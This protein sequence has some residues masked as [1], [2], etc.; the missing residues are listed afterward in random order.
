M[1]AN[2][3]IIFYL[4]I[5]FLFC[6]QS[7]TEEISNFTAT[8][9]SISLE[10]NRNH[11]EYNFLLDNA[12]YIIRIKT[13]EKNLEINRNIPRFFNN[14]KFPLKKHFRII[15][16]DP[17]TKK[18]TLDINSDI[19]YCIEDKDYHNRIG[20][21]NDNGEIGLLDKSDT[22][23]SNDEFINNNFLWNITP[24]ILN[25]EDNNKNI[26]KVYYYVKNIGTGKYLRYRKEFNYYLTCDTES[27]LNFTNDN[28]FKF[29]RMYREMIHNENNE[30]LEKEPID[31]LIKYIDLKDPDLKREG[32]T[33]I[34]KDVE[35]KEIK[36]SVRSIFKNIPWI[37][38]IFI[39]MPN[40]KVKY[41]KSPEEIKDKIVYVKD[42][43][44]LN[45]DSASSPVFQFNL[46]RMKNFG[47]SENFILMD[48][49]YFIGKPLKKSNFFY[50][51]NGQVFPSIVTRDYYELSKNDLQNEVN[52]LLSSRNNL[53]SQSPEAFNFMQKNT[54][55]FL[56]EILGDDNSRYGMPLIEPSFTHNAIP[57]KQSDI[58]EL[59]DY[60]EKLY[61]HKDETLRGKQRE[62]FCLQP[63]TLLMSYGRNKYD[64]ISKTIT[65]RFYDLTN[66]RGRI[67]DELFV[68]NTSDRSYREIIY[69]N[70]INYLENLYPEKTP[71]ELEI[72]DIN[73]GKRIIE[74]DNNNIKND[75]NII[76][77]DI[78]DFKKI[79]K[80]LEGNLE[81]KLEEKL[82]IK[83]L[84]N[85]EKILEEKLEKNLEEK[86]LEKL[87]TKLEEKLE[88]KLL[89]KLETKLE[90]KLE[91]KL[92]ENLEKKLLEKLEERL[93]EKIEI[94][95][96]EKL[97]TKLEEKL[98]VKVDKKVEDKIDA[99]KIKDKIIELFEKNNEINIKIETLTIEFNKINNDN[100]KLYKNIN[101]KINDNKKYIVIIIIIIC[102]II[103][104][105][106]IYYLI[107]RVCD[108]KQNYLYIDNSKEQKNNDNTNIEI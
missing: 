45:F 14:P 67:N 7:D 41:F 61:E 104:F 58:K 81:N 19:V 6:P 94:K 106:L 79:M 33:Q 95:L 73:N 35:N 12:I 16:I 60:I 42:K 87:E 20:V 88:E 71:Y 30:I 101:K 32:I 2:D 1:K 40:E 57:I 5:F 24:I 65:S 44:L 108:G 56:Y 15:A 23:G 55:L 48:D 34:K 82:E 53:N 27:T 13:G 105:L 50:E 99:I 51:E 38:K 89:E 8:N 31:V 63:Q 102:I 78:I 4:I 80:H 66:F 59:Y 83:L 98:E 62:K 18:Q 3:D 39:L 52:R 76:I 64:R 46:W 93:R 21:I 29:I 70:E 69:K 9:T 84:E 47:M 68:I 85:L 26:S 54:L 36:Y 10:E 97:E 28:Y 22:I 107:K 25:E 49:D 37:R 91:K 103:F 96:E 100:I 77:N 11:S 74:N 86:L 72:N 75:N 92:E 17:Q 43:D 90:E